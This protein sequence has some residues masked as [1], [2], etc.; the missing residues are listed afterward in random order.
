MPAD[1]PPGW[2]RSDPSIIASVSRRFAALVALLLLFCFGCDRGGENPVTGTSGKP[3]PTVDDGRPQDGGTL[4]RRSESEISTLNP[5]AGTTQYDRHVADYLF[6]PLIYQDQDLQPIPGLA[7]SWDV[8][9]GGRL[10]RFR[11]N[12]K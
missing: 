3:K 11:L 4:I 1:R 9:E 2:R 5:I 6:T 12:D 7:D 10:Y 8:E